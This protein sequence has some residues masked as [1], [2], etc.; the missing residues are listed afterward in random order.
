MIECRGEAT[1]EVAGRLGDCG[2]AAR[3]AGSKL[4]IAATSDAA[5]P[6]NISD[7]NAL[8]IEGELIFRPSVLR[9]PSR[10]ALRAP[11]ELRQLWAIDMPLG[12]II[13][14]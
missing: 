13:Q 6:N 2:S 5:V 3:V 4:P 9:S 10:E 14:I 11:E 12:Y 8:F 1:T 7:K